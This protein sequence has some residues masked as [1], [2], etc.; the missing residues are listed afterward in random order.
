MIPPQNTQKYNTSKGYSKHLYAYYTY[1]VDRLAEDLAH[2]V[3][4]LQVLGAHVTPA[5]AVGGQQLVAGRDKKAEGRVKRGLG[6]GV[7]E[8]FEESA[9][10]D[11]GLVE[12]LLGDKFD[13]YLPF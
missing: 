2:E 6:E 5:V 11:S 9:S 1:L 8:L 3:Q 12:P 7:D 10:V 4:V 13:F